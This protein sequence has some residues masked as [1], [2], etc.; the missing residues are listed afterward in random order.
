MKAIQHFVD[1]KNDFYAIANP[2]MPQLIEQVHK[3]EAKKRSEDVSISSGAEAFFA[4]IEG[5]LEVSVFKNE[6]ANGVPAGIQS[7]KV[8]AGYGAPILRKVLPFLLVKTFTTI[9]STVTSCP[10]YWAASVSGMTVELCAHTEIERLPKISPAKVSNRINEVII[11]LGIPNKMIS[12]YS[13]SEAALRVDR[14]RLVWCT[15]NS[16]GSFVR[17]ERPFTRRTASKLTL[18]RDAIEKSE[19]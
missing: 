2:L 12:A 11:F 10:T 13:K 8:W 16:S 5:F 7:V 19:I 9:P 1:A 17:K 3:V 4:S 15:Y 6:D 14:S 18:N